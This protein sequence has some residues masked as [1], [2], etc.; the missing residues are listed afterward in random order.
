MLVGKFD[1]NGYKTDTHFYINAAID[2]DLWTGSFNAEYGDLE[3]VIG[4]ARAKKVF[5][6]FKLLNKAKSTDL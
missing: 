2:V 5:Q 6:Y 3:S 4:T 1:G